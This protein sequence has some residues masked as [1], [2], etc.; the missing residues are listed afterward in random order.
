MRTIAATV[1]MLAFLVSGVRVHTVEGLLHPQK[2]KPDY[3]TTDSN[4]RPWSQQ[5]ESWYPKYHPTLKALSEGVCNRT[6]HDYQVSFNAPA[7]SSEYLQLLSIC[8]QHER[9]LFDGLTTDQQI[10]FQTAGIV[11]GI[12]PTMMS[13]I[14]V[15][16]AETALL[17]A[18]R[19]VLSFLLS[20]AA[21]AV[22]PTRV[23]EYN[24]PA[25]LLARGPGK[26]ELQ[27]LGPWKAGLL[28][29]LEY[30]FAIAAVVNVCLLSWDMGNKTILSWGC[31][32]V[33]GPLLWTSLTVVLHSI[34]ALS[35]NMV[36]WQLQKKAVMQQEKKTPL[37]RLRLILKEEF[38]T[39]ANH[40]VPSQVTQG[41]QGNIPA[42]AVV[43]NIVAGGAS[44][45]QLAFGTIVFSSLIFVSVWDVLNCI[46]WRFVLST[47][48]AR[49]VLIIEVAGLRAANSRLMYRSVDLRHETDAT[50]V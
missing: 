41:D 23:F 50:V 3:F 14:G 15:S 38:T 1:L 16:I 28:S 2:E 11:L 10:N 8:Y 43:L 37:R 45:I 5:F 7:G 27:Q 18:H 49:L 34:S 35:Y 6:L 48:V 19:P 33:I 13:W 22:W 30:T 4:L 42:K 40:D 47:S 12:L 24:N 31:T 25:D 17:S 46:L 9:C 20:L 21:P 44:F 29:L 32:N 39:C 36:K 26:P